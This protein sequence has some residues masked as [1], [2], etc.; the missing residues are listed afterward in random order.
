MQGNFQDVLQYGLSR[1]CQG[2]QKSDQFQ[3][4]T[5]CTFALAVVPNLFQ[6][7]APL[8]YWAIGC[9]FPFGLQSYSIGYEP[10]YRVKGLFWWPLSSKIPLSSLA[11]F[12]SFWGAIACSLGTTG[13]GSSEEWNHRTMDFLLSATC[14]KGPIHFSAMGR[15]QC[16][17]DTFWSSGAGT[18][19][20][21]ICHH[22]AT[23]KLY[24]QNQEEIINL[25]ILN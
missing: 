2:R 11:G 16:W 23:L 19:H 9:A 21:T 17:T 25:K 7:A 12:P 10:I 13:R 1:I 5:K 3:H 15:H 22:H 14:L 6:L 18:N 20:G 8:N 24:Y 4:Y